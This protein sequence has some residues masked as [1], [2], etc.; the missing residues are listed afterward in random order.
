MPIWVEGTGL[1]S[2][3]GFRLIR[4]DCVNLGAELSQLD[5]KKVSSVTCGGQEKAKPGNR[6]LSADSQDYFTKDPLGSRLG[7]QKIDAGSGK[8]DGSCGGRTDCAN[9]LLAGLLETGT[10]HFGE[11]IKEELRSVGA[12]KSKPIVGLDSRDSRSIA[13]NCLGR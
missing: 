1:E 3:V 7:D 2:H 6:A 4:L 5:R 11:P 12:C 8:L 9:G 10:L 13:S